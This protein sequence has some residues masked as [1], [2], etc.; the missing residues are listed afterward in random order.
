MIDAAARERNPGA[1]S[2]DFLEW[3]LPIDPTSEAVAAAE[4]GWFAGL[5]HVCSCGDW[6]DVA[7]FVLVQNFQPVLRVGTNCGGVWQVETFP[8]KLDDAAAAVRRGDRAE[9]VAKRQADKVSSG[10]GK[11]GVGPEL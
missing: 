7:D 2:F 8:A 1:R 9:I 4:K 6:G 11:F 5:W 3:D 10:S